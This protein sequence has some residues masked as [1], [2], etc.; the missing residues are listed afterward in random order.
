ML[1]KQNP[2]LLII[3]MFLIEK[4]KPQY[5]LFSDAQDKLNIAPI[6]G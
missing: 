1:A 6:R 2:S 5:W 3:D 4:F